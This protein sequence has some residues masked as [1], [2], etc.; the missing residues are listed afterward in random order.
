LAKTYY[1]LQS[2]KKAL[3]TS[4]KAAKTG[5]PKQEIIELA[6]A[7]RMGLESSEEEVKEAESTAADSS[8]SINNDSTAAS[9]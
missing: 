6:K 2:F 1:E 5:E 8:H 7:C 3:E 9:E 4:T